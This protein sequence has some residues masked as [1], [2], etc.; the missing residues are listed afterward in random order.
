MRQLGA[1]EQHNTGGKGALDR[2]P[3]PARP[4]HDG[5]ALHVT[6]Q[7]RIDVA[8]GEDVR[9][10]DH[11]APLIAHQLGRHEAQRRKGLQ[12][13]HAPGPGRAATAELLPFV[14]AHEGIVLGVDER[15]VE[16][17]GIGRVALQRVLSDQGADD[18]LV[19]GVDEDAG[20]HGLTI[21]VA[22]QHVG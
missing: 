16:L 14:R 7:Q 22:V 13:F 3:P 1:V 11:R 2:L 21:F 20:F 15:D 6:G 19:I 10:D 9:V 18:L 17:V 8:G 12:V 4:A 5:L